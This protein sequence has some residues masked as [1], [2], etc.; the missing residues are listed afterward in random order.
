VQKIS[1][2]L[3]HLDKCTLYY[4]KQAQDQAACI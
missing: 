1:A 3:Q 2:Y 4:I